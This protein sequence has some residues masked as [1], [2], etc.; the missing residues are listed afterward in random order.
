MQS[1]VR[2]VKYYFRKS[3]FYRLFLIGKEQSTRH[4]FK[5]YYP[6]QILLRC[7]ALAVYLLYGIRAKEFLRFRLDEKPL[8][9]SRKYVDYIECRFLYH[10]FNSVKVRRILSDKFASYQILSEFYKRNMTLIDVEDINSGIMKDRVIEFMGR[11]NPT[12]VFKPRRSYSGNGVG[13]YDNV[14]E[15]CELLTI[16][17]GGCL[18]S[19]IVQREELAGF[20]ASSVNTIRINTVN[21][22]EGDVEVVW[23]SFRMG[24]VGSFV[25]N[26]GCGG[27]FGAIDVETGVVI[28]A[29]DEYRN[30][31]TEHP[32]SHKRIIGFVVPEWH[33]ACNIVKQMAMKLPDAAFVGWDLALTKEG[34]VLVEGNGAPLIIWQMA[35]G[36]GIRNK[37][38]EIENK[39]MSKKKL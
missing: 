29:A 6:N 10:I 11:G 7:K 38:N 37:F 3:L 31:Y 18:E 17:K 20:N 13:V 4:S 21:Y 14:E 32:D 34:W 5:K 19:L 16:N 24:R 15:I 22:G 23:P 1:F 36:I 33:E 12:I 9:E 39:L 28:G 25:D 35:S 30:R 26:A 27:V 8:R 2:T